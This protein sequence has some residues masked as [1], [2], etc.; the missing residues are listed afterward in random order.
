MTHTQGSD[1]YQETIRDMERLDSTDDERLLACLDACAG[2]PTD[3]LRPG[4]VKELME[5]LAQAQQQWAMYANDG[6]D[7]AHDDDTESRMWR[8]Q[9]ALLRELGEP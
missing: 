9:R 7:L 6:R 2:I 8:R 3:K 1:V 5:A 4:I